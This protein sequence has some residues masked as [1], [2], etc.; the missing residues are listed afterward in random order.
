MRDGPGGGFLCVFVGFAL[1]AKGLC[2]CGRRRIK[3][4]GFIELVKPCRYLGGLRPLLGAGLAWR[5][6]CSSAPRP[7]CGISSEPADLTTPPIPFPTL[8]PTSPH[9]PGLGDAKFISPEAFLVQVTT[10]W[11]GSDSSLKL[12]F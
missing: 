2:A 8:P 6:L 11:L 7:D 3:E 9:L 1:A 4:R 12:P 10:G 5:E